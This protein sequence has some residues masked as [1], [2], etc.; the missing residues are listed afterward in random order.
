MKNTVHIR[1]YGCQMNE[2]DSEAVGALLRDYGYEI[3]PDESSANV[4]IV[5]TCS[6]RQK[7]EDKALG[8][9]RL[10][11]AGKRTRPGRVVG[12]MGC[13]V[14]RLGT[15]ILELVPGLDFAVGPDRC[16]A[17]PALV[18]DALAGSAAV[19]D[20]RRNGHSPAPPTGHTT[21]G[22]TAFVN[23][24]FGCSRGCSYCIVP[25]V[26]G[27]EWS[28]PAPDIR[29]EVAG[30][31]AG[32]VREVCLLGQ[33][34]M[35]YGRRQDVWGQAPASPRGF[36]EPFPRLLEALSEIDGLA[37]IRFTSGHPAGCTA[38]LARAIR[39]LPPVCEHLHLPLQS[40]SDRMLGLMRRGYNRAAY[41]EAVDRLRAGSPAIALTTDIIVGFPTETDEEFECTRAFMEE[42]AFDNAFVFKY[43]PRPGTPAA[44]MPDDVSA[45]E[46]MRRN[47]V[48]LADQERRA[49]RILAAL[50]GATL[51]VLVEG[52]SKRNRSRWT[53][54]TRTNKIVVFEPAPG[55]RIGDMAR[56]R[57]ERA[58]GLSLIGAVVS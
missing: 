51:D 24:L 2:R 37:R 8:K 20:T 3:S 55:M 26:R 6:V 29:R 43:S 12:A 40:G 9:L 19:V 23:V 48:L 31:V 38:E 52:E 13:M 33:S 44:E 49:T 7:A 32:G 18:R 22:P 35:S 50:V 10:L 34:V 36:A 57:V 11:T 4:V 47:K 14:Q 16:A 30:L 27:P 42:I 46:K 28:R 58:T 15:R 1:T 21:R 53:G 25:A 56:V 39:D 5:N 45:E 17:L 41:R 54:R